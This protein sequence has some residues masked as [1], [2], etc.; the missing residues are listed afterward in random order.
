MGANRHVY[1]EIDAE[2]EEID[3]QISCCDALLGVLFPWALVCKHRGCGVEAFIT[4]ALNL[5]LGFLPGIVYAFWVVEEIPFCHNV[6]CL[7]LPPFG[8][9]AKKGHCDVQVAVC[10]VLWLTLVGGPWYAYW[11]YWAHNDKAC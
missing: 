8:L 9:L 6:M 3:H 1:I 4:L 2:G 5:L 10:A 7:M 11:K